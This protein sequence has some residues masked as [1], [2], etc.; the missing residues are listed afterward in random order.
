M[1]LDMGHCLGN[2]PPTIR[3]VI[4]PLASPAC[5]G[6]SPE[7]GRWRRPIDD[8]LHATLAQIK[9]EMTIMLLTLSVHSSVDKSACRPVVWASEAGF[10]GVAATLGS[11]LN[12]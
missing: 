2:M 11:G 12:G 7:A 4:S 6:L 5:G 10:L 9:S 1:I 8:R 3:T